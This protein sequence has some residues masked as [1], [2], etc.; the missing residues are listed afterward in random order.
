MRFMSNQ[1]IGFLPTALLFCINSSRGV[2][3][4]FYGRRLRQAD[5][6]TRAYVTHAIIA[7]PRSM[8]RI[9]YKRIAYMSDCI[10]ISHNNTSKY[11]NL[12][13]LLHLHASVTGILIHSFQDDNVMSTLCGFRRVYQVYDIPLTHVDILQRPPIFDI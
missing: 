12:Y 2:L 1:I 7:Q 11:P 8:R 13:V 5:R 10:E 3:S 6:P 9:L 4:K